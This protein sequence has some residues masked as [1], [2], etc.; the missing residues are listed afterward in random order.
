MSQETLPFRLSERCF[1]EYEPYI[2]QAMHV[3]P[4]SYQVL[5]RSG[6]SQNTVEARLRDSIRSLMQFRWT[7]S[8]DMVK[9]ERVYDDLVVRRDGENVEIALRGNKTQTTTLIAATLEIQP[10]YASTKVIHAVCCLVS[11]GVLPSVC[12]KNTTASA[13]VVPPEFTDIVAAERAGDVY[14][15]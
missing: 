13:I 4:S 15:M 9:F 10:A 5:P 11:C 3:L 2:A 8:V 1:R 6:R 14:I 7:T 12:F